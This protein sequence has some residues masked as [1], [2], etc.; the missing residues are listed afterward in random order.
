MDGLPTG[1]MLSTRLCATP[2]R[3]SGGRG[4]S[5]HPGHRGSIDSGYG[6][7]IPRHLKDM[8]DDLE[9]QMVVHQLAGQR[10]RTHHK[11]Y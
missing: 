9:E 4:Y 10:A 8:L 7:S 3:R 6:N 2:Q 5:G 1:A 11:H